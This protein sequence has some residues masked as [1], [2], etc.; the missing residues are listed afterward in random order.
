VRTEVLGASAALEEATGQKWT[1][2]RVL[3]AHK[4]G[5]DVTALLEEP[6]RRVLLRREMDKRLGDGKAKFNAKLLLE[7]LPQVGGLDG[8]YGIGGSKG[9]L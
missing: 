2:D 8:V 5:L 7:E 9:R 1:V 4:E 3:Q 6:A